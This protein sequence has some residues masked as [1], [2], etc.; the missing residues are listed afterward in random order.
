MLQ[1]CS[2]YMVVEDALIF[3][4]SKNKRL[5]VLVLIID[6]LSKIVSDDFW[7]ITM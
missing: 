3:F 1:Q 5:Q 4:A 7:T 2:C 6:V